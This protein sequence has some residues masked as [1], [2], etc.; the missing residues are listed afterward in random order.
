MY[1]SNI[2]QEIELLATFARTSNFQ[3]YVLHQIHKICPNADVCEAHFE[4]EPCPDCFQ[5]PDR[6]LESDDADFEQ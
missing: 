5:L 2:Q 6:V 1:K 3:G 4:I